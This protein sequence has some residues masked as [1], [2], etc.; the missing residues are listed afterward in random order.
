MERIM[1]KIDEYFSDAK[2][3]NVCDSIEGYFANDGDQQRKS[4]G[5]FGSGGGG[6]Y[7]P[8]KKD[9]EA[10]GASSPANEV[11]SSKARIEQHKSD[12]KRK[13][14]ALKAR[15]PSKK[16]STEIGVHKSEIKRHEENI[17]KNG[18]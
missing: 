14:A 15:G 7:S 6:S 5:Q 12:I 13:E 11:S 3:T 4:N 1:G 10:R 18:G 9:I 8:P 17:K 2:K 16:I